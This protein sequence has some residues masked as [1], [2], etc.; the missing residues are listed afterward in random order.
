MKRLISIGG[1]EPEYKT[2]EHVIQAMKKAMDDGHTHY[3]NF[4]HILE[5]REAVAAKYQKLG[6]DVDPELVI[7]TPGSTM[8]IFMVF[9]A[10]MKRGDDLLT[11]DPAFF[12][13]YQPIEYLGINAVPVPRHKEEGWKF[14]TED[15]Y[16]KTT[17]KTKALL[18]CSPD[19]PTGAVL[20]D[21]DLKGIADYTK[22]KDKWVI[23]DDIYDEITYD[24]HKFKSIA[25][26]PGMQERTV[27]LNGLSKTYA[28]TGWRVGYIIAP[29]KELYDTLF[30][31]Q[32]CTF[33]VL[34]AALQRA[35]IAALTGPQDCVKEM[36]AKYE[37]KRDCV[38]DAWNDI[39]KVTVTKPEGA[40][41]TFPDLSEYGLSSPKMAKYIRDEA[42]VAITPGHLF[43]K[44]GEGH[45]RNAYAQSM[46]DL[47]E[48]LSR[49]K[50]AL[51]K[52]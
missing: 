19:N 51:A 23:S 12:G 14:H 48:G 46:P 7:I 35:S 13:Y 43:G 6:V 31:T 50:K 28:M 15:L 10:L 17:D 45:I 29:N 20:D 25:T 18:I 44:N 32:M 26:L 38:L 2:P 3:G 34:N 36:V 33:L 30:T 9:D 49:I 39:P 11:M 37:K 16:E 41:Y 4:R 22:E 24:G 8:G 47:E 21:E 40:F 5:L 42:N 27:I 1:G 52:L